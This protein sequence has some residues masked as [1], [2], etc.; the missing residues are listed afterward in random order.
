MLKLH[1][2]R[3]FTYARMLLRIPQ[4]AFCDN[5][6]FIPFSMTNVTSKTFLFALCLDVQIVDLALRRVGLTFWKR[7]VSRTAC[8]GGF[9][10]ESCNRKKRRLPAL[11]PRVMP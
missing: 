9:T 11:R 5:R 8:S 4:L 7:T 10:S 1:A 3:V 2:S 6:S